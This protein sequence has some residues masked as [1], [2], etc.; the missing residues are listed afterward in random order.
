M[1]SPPSSA[2]VTVSSSRLSHNS[3]FFK[4]IDFPHPPPYP[5]KARGSGGFPV[6][7][8]VELLKFVALARCLDSSEIMLGKSMEII[9]YWKVAMVENA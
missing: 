5:I 4:L 7:H 6:P 8:D 1:I 2:G 9:H 3:T